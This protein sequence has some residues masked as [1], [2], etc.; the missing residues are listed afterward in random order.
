MPSK[1]ALGVNSTLS[2]DTMQAPIS[3]DLNQSVPRKPSPSPLYATGGASNSSAKAQTQPNI[4][5]GGAFGSQSSFDRTGNSMRAPPQQMNSTLAK[6]PQQT[7]QEPLGPQPSQPSKKQQQASNR[8]R[9]KVDV[10]VVHC[11]ACCYNCTVDRT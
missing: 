6:S 5:G 10:M 2:K 3:N 8:F 9:G 11:L 4:G 7:L 1:T